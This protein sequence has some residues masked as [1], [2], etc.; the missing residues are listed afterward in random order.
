MSG[1]SSARARAIRPNSS[2][3]AATSAFASSMVKNRKPSA[4]IGNPGIIVL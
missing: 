1:P 3:S 4:M 2:C